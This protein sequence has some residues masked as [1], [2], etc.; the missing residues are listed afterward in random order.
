MR[1]GYNVRHRNDRQELILFQPER[2]LLQSAAL[3]IESKSKPLMQHSGIRQEK[4]Q[5]NSQLI[6]L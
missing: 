5:Y 2:S 4:A 1:E 3:E 6:R